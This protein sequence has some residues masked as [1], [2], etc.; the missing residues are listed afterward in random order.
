MEN[1]KEFERR[2]KRQTAKVSVSLP[3]SPPLDNSSSTLPYP[4]LLSPPPS[5]SILCV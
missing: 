3:L 1:S 5:N 4:S 2:D